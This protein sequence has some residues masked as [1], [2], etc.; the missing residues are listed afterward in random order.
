[1]GG[2]GSLAKGRYVYRQGTGV[3]LGPEWTAL[4]GFDC[5]FILGCLQAP[6]SK[7][8]LAVCLS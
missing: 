4:S 8:C 5:F 3:C 7:P 6:G 1:M 2:S